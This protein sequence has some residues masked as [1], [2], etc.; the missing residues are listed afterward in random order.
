M[1]QEGNCHMLQLLL[2]VTVTCYWLW[3]MKKK[4]TLVVALLHVT[5]LAT[6]P[7]IKNNNQLYHI[8]YF[9]INNVY[10]K[11]FGFLC[12]LNHSFEKS[13]GF[14]WLLRGPA[15]RFPWKLVWHPAPGLSQ[16]MTRGLLWASSV[17]KLFL[18]CIILPAALW[19]RST[20]QMRKQTLRRLLTCPGLPAVKKGI[21]VQTVILELNLLI[22]KHPI[23]LPKSCVAAHF[24][25]RW[26]W[27]SG[28]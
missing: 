26:L 4:T 22:S 28:S 3:E 16:H 2:H 14:I 21:G 18:S 8:Y 25:A 20:L 13:Q 10:F 12:N 1:F 5:E 9:E 6:H 23:F 15:L 24:Y 27:F 7:P 11:I 19:G 17:T